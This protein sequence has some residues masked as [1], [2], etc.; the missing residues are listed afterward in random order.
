[1]AI[2]RAAAPGAC[3]GAATALA[4]APRRPRRTRRCRARRRVVMHRADAR[5]LRQPGLLQRL[6]HAVADPL[7]VPPFDGRDRDAGDEHLEVQVIA[8][9]QAGAAAVAELLALGDRVAD[10]DVQ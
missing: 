2:P 8:H 10:L 4:A 9:G 1:A 7:A 3:G 6:V 5:D